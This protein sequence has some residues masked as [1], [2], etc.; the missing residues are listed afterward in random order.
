LAMPLD[1]T[2]DYQNSG[3]FLASDV[4]ADFDKMYIGGIQNENEGSRSLRLQEVEPTIAM[5]LPLKADRLGKFL[6]FNA[7]TGIPQAMTGEGATSSDLVSY[8]PAGTGAVATTV[9][10][11][12]RESVSV[13]D[14]G[15]TGDGTTNDTA[16]IQAAIDY[17]KTQINADNIYPLVTASVFFPA[18]QYSIASGSSL[19][20]SRGIKLYGESSSLVKLIHLGGTVPC[21]KTDSAVTSNNNIQI[22]DLEI[23]G[24]GAGTTY[25]IYFNNSIYNSKIENVIIRNCNVNFKSLDS[26]SLYIERC[27]FDSSIANN[28]EFE[29]ATAIYI[30]NS[31][32]DNGGENNAYITKSPTWPSVHTIFEGCTIQRAQQEGIKLI[33][34]DSANVTNSYFEGNNIAN[35]N[36]ADIHWAHG[37]ATRGI[38]LNVSNCYASATTGGDTNKFIYA[39]TAG[40]V[41]VNNTRTYDAAGTYAYLV[42]IDLGASIRACYINSS[43]IEATTRV[44]RASTNTGLIDPEQG[45]TYYRSAISNPIFDG[46]SNLY[47]T[48][49]AP[50]NRRLAIALQSGGV[51]KWFVG[52]GDTDEAQ[53][54]MFF[55]ARNNAGSA[56]SILID[57]DDSV[58]LLGAWD[59]GALRLGAY[60][61]WIDGSG[62]LMINASQ[63]SSISDGTVV[64]TQT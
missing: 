6:G 25:G 41:N 30:T 53:A 1:R 47:P 58:K 46:T 55:V 43:K 44:V 4:N 26:W 20:V 32:I 10:T 61:L 40:D 52:R 29:N 48:F 12:L 21:I 59:S 18:G 11:K 34:V 38:N 62:K 45:E 36:H 16:A 14:F 56:A 15:A 49:N 33:D 28:I 3:D 42:G 7:I 51:D 60:W 9:Q 37:A 54:D 22:Q 57:S 64:G 31:R 5:T 2:T 27:H 8:A 23:Y 17:A 39:A 19:V 35:S 50:A 24:V 13:K 63:P